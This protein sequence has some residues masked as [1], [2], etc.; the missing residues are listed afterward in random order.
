MSIVKFPGYGY[1]AGEQSIVATQ[2]QFWHQIDYNGD[3]G[4]KIHFVGDKS[5]MVKAS[6]DDVEKAVAAALKGGSAA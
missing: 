6:P 5:V 3:R 4:T 2:I 1:G